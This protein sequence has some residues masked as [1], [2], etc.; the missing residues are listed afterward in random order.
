[1]LANSLLC[2]YVDYQQWKTKQD[3]PF[4]QKGVLYQKYMEMIGKR[5]PAPVCFGHEGMCEECNVPLLKI[6]S[7]STMVCSHCGYSE[8]YM[9]NTPRTLPYGHEIN[10]TQSTYKRI[11]GLQTSQE[12]HVSDELTRSVFF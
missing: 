12:A 9:E 5:A 10:A 6:E 11:V 2:R 3:N 7:N 4:S 1:M 8:Q